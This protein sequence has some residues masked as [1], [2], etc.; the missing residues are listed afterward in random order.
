MKRKVK[1]LLE[2]LKTVVWKSCSLQ[3]FFE[4]ILIGKERKKKMKGA[5]FDL[6]GTLL[7]SMPIWEK[8]GELFLAGIGKKA[9]P[10]LSAMLFSMSMKEGAVFLKERYNLTMEVDDIIAGVNHTIEEQYRR[11]ILLKDGAASF[12]KKMQQ[13]GIKMVVATACDRCVLEEAL[14]RLQIM[15][16]FETIFTCTEVGASKKSPHIYLKAAE[17]L[18]VLPKDIWVFEDA[19]YA[20]ETAK[21]AGFKTVGVFDPSNKKDKEKTLHISDLYIESFF[22]V[23]TL[24]A[25]IK[26]KNG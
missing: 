5:I 12:L 19:L 14:V 21:K 9:E 17:Y 10:N 13:A 11:Q 3:W 22:E 15:H 4:Y 23:L 18:D 26:T 8:A 25:I 6:D 24:P 16:Y 1:E 20:I 7:D 2:L